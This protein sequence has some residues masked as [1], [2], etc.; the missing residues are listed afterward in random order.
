M[1]RQW[2]TCEKCNRVLYV[3]D[4]PVCEDCRA[5]EPEAAREPEAPQ[6]KVPDFPKKDAGER[7]GQMR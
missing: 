1:S 4:G 6:A 2:T 7:K 5:K 3:E